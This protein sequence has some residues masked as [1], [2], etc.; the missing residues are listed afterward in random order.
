MIKNVTKG[1][2][3]LKTKYASHETVETMVSSWK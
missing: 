3:P 1:Q 2:T